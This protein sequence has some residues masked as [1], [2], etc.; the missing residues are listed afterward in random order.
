MNRKSHD[1]LINESHSF[2]FSGNKKIK[3][4]QQTKPVIQET[5]NNTRL[6]SSV[7]QLLSMYEYQNHFDIQCKKRKLS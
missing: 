7:V 2:Y 3:R 6:K 5:I 4:K 1:Y